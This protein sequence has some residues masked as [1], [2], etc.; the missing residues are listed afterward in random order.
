MK[1]RDGRESFDEEGFVRE[2]L[3]LGRSDAGVWDLMGD[4]CQLG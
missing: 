3:G 1:N 4:V 2:C